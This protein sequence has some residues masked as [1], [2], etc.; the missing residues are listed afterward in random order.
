MRWHNLN[1]PTGAQA[2]LPDDIT[3]RFLD[4][5]DLTPRQLCAT[6]YIPWQVK[7]LEHIPK[8]YQEFFK[9]VLPHLGNRATNVH[10]ALSVAQI[11]FLLQHSTEPA[12]SRIVYLAVILHDTGWSKVSQQ[13]IADSLSYSGVA[14]TSEASVLPKQQHI[15]IGAALAYDLLDAYD[16]EDKPLSE[17]DKRHISQIIRRHDYDSVWDRGKFPELSTET[18]LVCDADRLWS[19]THENF[20]Q[21]TVRKNVQPEDY[22]STISGEIET[23]F[24]TP[25]GKVRAHGLVAERHKEVAEYLAHI[26]Q[27]TTEAS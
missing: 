16:F 20:W 25:Q 15:L 19:F 23:Y 18:K 2:T 26:T 14:P 9:H 8:E 27:T 3:L 21:D 11:S 17:A 10:T 24:I 4:T 22:L 1:L 13:G 5:P 6:A 7:F 12:D